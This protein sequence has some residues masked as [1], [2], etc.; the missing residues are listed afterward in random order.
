[1]LPVLVE[2][3]RRRIDDEPRRIRRVEIAAPV[4]RDVNLLRLTD[5]LHYL[6]L[7]VLRR[8]GGCNRTRFVGFRPC[9]GKG[10]AGCGARDHRGQSREHHARQQGA[11]SRSRPR[12]A[13]A[14]FS[15]TR[16]AS[17]R[18]HVPSYHAASI[19][20]V[21][22]E[23][24][25]SP[26]RHSGLGYLTWPVLTISVGTA[27]VMLVQPVPPPAPLHTHVPPGQDQNKFAPRTSMRVGLA[28]VICDHR[29]IPSPGAEAALSQT[30]LGP[31]ASIWSGLAAVICDHVAVVKL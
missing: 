18:T 12:S 8:C 22:A 20:R 25:R 2:N 10:C 1:M 14:V 30:R 28:P 17:L 27:A 23:G 13:R 3:L 6:V 24:T 26:P 31:H 16:L 21:N 15:S 9:T 7:R 5:L 11:A 19:V 29:P 4:D